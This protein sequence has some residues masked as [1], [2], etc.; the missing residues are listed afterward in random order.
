MLLYMIPPFPEF[1]NLELSDKKDVENFTKKSPPYSDF[2]FVSMWSWN[3]KNET[4]L[5]E[6]NGNL[7]VR[8]SDY[9]SKEIFYS[10]IGSNKVEETIDILTKFSLKNKSGSKLR[11]I[12]E[13][14]IREHRTGD[15]ILISDNDNFD[16]VYDVK[17]FFT[18]E[19]KKYETQ[20]N[21]INRFEKKYQN[22][23][24]EIFKDFDHVKEE[25]LLL[26]QSWK[27]NK[28]KQDKILEFRSESEALRRIFDLKHDGLFTVCIFSDNKL[29]AFCVSEVLPE[30]DYAISHFAKAD[31]SFS[32]IYSFLLHKTCEA[33][34]K[35]K[36]K[37]LNYEQ[38]LGLVYL[39]NSK[40]AFRPV[41]F[42]KKY[43]I[44]K[45]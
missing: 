37:Y 32:G 43:L 17:E 4:K 42:L 1:K 27:L 6:L 18:C 8:F 10:F 5:S 11:L 7:V 14:V 16:Y 24:V 26:E 20:R 9:L 21:Q 34:I 35:H 19:G 3:T 29:V 36:V 30:S 25:M 13:D 38:D 33:L 12:P 2:N 44:I 39:K 40:M 31:I 23:K 41:H 45:Q 15:F 28:V 22:I